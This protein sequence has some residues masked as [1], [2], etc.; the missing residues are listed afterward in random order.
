MYDSNTSRSN[1]E[2]ITRALDSM[3]WSH[4]AAFRSRPLEPYYYRNFTGSVVKAGTRKT[5]GYLTLATV[6]DA[7]H[8]SPHDQPEAVSQVVQ[9]WLLKTAART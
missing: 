7:G 3:P 1:T 8:M 2:G 9:Q 4:M 6:D 5:A